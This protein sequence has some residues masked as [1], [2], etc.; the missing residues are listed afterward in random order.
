M[1]NQLKR[2][3]ADKLILSV[4]GVSSEDGISTYHYM[5]SEINRQMIARAKRPLLLLIIPKLEEPA[6]LIFLHWKILIF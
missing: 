2:Y 3:K 1:I 6:L 4:D 5:E